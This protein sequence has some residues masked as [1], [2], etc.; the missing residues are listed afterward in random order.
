MQQPV[1]VG[2]VPSLQDCTPFERKARASVFILDSCTVL[3]TFPEKQQIKYGFCQNAVWI[4][5]C[6][7]TVRMRIQPKQQSPFGQKCAHPL[8][9]MSNVSPSNLRLHHL[10]S[11][12]DAQQ[13][14]KCGRSSFQKLGQNVT[15]RIYMCITQLQSKTAPTR[16]LKRI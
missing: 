2:Q 9:T 16:S 10:S 15:S 5:L 8:T 11:Q 4:I 12:K 1:K 14:A 7:G 3:T 13:K 6:C